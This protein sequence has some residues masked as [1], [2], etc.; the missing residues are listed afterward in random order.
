MSTRSTE[1]M[2][3]GQILE[4]AL[5]QRAASGRTTSGKPARP[6][7][8][9]ANQDGYVSFEYASRLLGMQN[10]YSSRYIKGDED[11][12]VCGTGLRID[13]DVHDY[14]D[15]LIHVDDVEEFVSRVQKAR[16]ERGRA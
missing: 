14:H 3:L 5:A 11:H 2:S 7:C 6:T 16:G 12:E 13:G 4:A 8:P 9:P 10:Q 15:L 1:G